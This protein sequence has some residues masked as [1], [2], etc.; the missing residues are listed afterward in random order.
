MNTFNSDAEYDLLYQR[1]PIRAQAHHLRPGFTREQA[2][3]FFA[4][5]RVNEAAHRQGEQGEPGFGVR[6]DELIESGYTEIR[7]TNRW[8]FLDGPDGSMRFGTKAEREYIQL[9]LNIGSM[10][11]SY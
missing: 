1:D 10:K 2:E 3:R 5:K 8:T 9:V 7:T 4:R 11:R 6:I